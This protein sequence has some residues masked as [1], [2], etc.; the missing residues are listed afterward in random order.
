MKYDNVFLTKR[1]IEIMDKIRYGAVLYLHIADA[2]FLLRLGFIAPYALSDAGDE[3]V[4]S[5]EG[6]RYMEY[7]DNK[8]ENENAKKLKEKQKEEKEWRLQWASII[9]SNGIALA[10][11][12]VSIMK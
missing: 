12:I 9:I 1:D 7:L 11:L 10:A 3:Y 6:C 4:V 8:R 5:A 2:Q